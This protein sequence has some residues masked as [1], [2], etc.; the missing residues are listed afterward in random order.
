MNLLKYLDVAVCVG[1]LA[2]SGLGSGCAAKAE[3]EAG[4]PAPR[5]AAAAGP[6][7]SVLTAS[8][9]SAHVTRVAYKT[10]VAPDKVKTVLDL[11][12]RFSKA[13]NSGQDLRDIAVLGSEQ[14]GLTAE[15]AAGVLLEYKSLFE[16]GPEQEPD[17]AQAGP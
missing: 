7:A 12:R 10:G 9:E 16:G 17:I 6:A 8:D 13:K 15:E 14:T 1:A 11:Y 5:P 2:V 3:G 4:A